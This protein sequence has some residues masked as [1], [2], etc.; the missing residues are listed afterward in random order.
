MK[1]LWAFLVELIMSPSSCIKHLCDG[2]FWLQKGHFQLARSAKHPG[3]GC[4]K[5]WK[6]PG[7]SFD[8]S[9]R[10]WF[11]DISVFF[12]LVKQQNQ[13]MFVYFNV[14]PWGST[15]VAYLFLPFTSFLQLCRL[16]LWEGDL[17]PWNSIFF[18]LPEVETVTN[19]ASPCIKFAS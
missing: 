14:L 16:P 10:T 3:C 19:P 6:G 5:G 13:I 8:M 11:V 17:K 9:D 12:Y 15:S 18:P 7:C 2:K 1:Q 4:W